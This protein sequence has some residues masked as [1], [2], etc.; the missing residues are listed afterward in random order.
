[1]DVSPGRWKLM[2]FTWQ[3]DRGRQKLVDGASQDCVDW[4]LR[5]VYQPHYDHFKDDF[6][7]TIAGFF[8][9]EPETHGDWGTEVPKVLAEKGVDWKPAYVAWKFQ[10]AGDIQA[11]ARYAYQEAFSEAWGRT[12]YGG[13][14][15]WCHAHGVTSF[16]HLMEHEREYLEQ[17]RCAG[18]MMQLQKYSDMGAIDA[19]FKQ[20]APGRKDDNTYQTPKLGSSISHAYGKADDVTMVE[21]FGA[22]TGPRLPR[23]EV[24]DRP[25]AGR[26]CELPDPALVQPAP[27]HDTDCPPYFY[28]GGYEPRYPL[29][30]VLADYT[31]RLSLMLSGGRHACPVAFL[32]LGHSQ[33]VGKSITP[34]N[35]TTALQDALFD[36]D[37]LPYEVFE[38]NTRLDGKELQL[39]QERYKVLIVPPVEVIPYAT[40]AKAR[41]F[42]EQG[43]VVVGYGL[44][45]SKSATLGRTS[46]DIQALREAIWGDLK[47]RGS[48]TVC[49]T[50]LAGGRSYFL[51]E[52]PTV[53]QI[54]QV[55][56]A[57]AGIHPDLEVVEG[58]TN[59][60][61]HVTPPGEGRTRRVP[62]LQPEPRRQ[63]RGTSR[64]GPGPKAYRSAGTPCATRSRGFRS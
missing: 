14:T 59:Q 36:C 53:R 35:M 32:F 45:P 44:L 30:R 1:M 48:V 52:Q 12:M 63:S 13:M 4:F 42:F 5:T 8:Y 40:L 2:I 64:F 56:T 15:R 47:G 37:W 55:L 62:G 24:V 17:D 25:D 3:P 38:N 54:Q 57:D 18:N 49:K 7:K 26:G 20:F 60:W 28:N 61:L 51:P 27:P 22:G 43:G 21:I 31:S 10:L 29:Y 58:D 23:D 16:G 46:A 33:Q 11:A 50:S 41:R 19:V 6:G 9:D 39:R 34:E